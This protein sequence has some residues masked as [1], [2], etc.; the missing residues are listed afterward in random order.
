MISFLLIFY[1]LL[2]VPFLISS[3]TITNINIAE[4]F[5]LKFYEKVL[6]IVMENPR[7]SD[8]AYFPSSLRESLDSMLVADP[9]SSLM[10]MCKIALNLLKI[11]LEKV[12]NFE[13]ETEQEIYKIMESCLCEFLC[14]NSYE[15][16]F[17]GIDD[18]MVS[19]PL[20][21][22]ISEFELNRL[23]NLSFPFEPLEA[24]E[25]QDEVS[26]AVSCKK[27]KHEIE[28]ERDLDSEL[29]KSLWS[30]AIDSLAEILLKLSILTQEVEENLSQL[31]SSSADEIAISLSNNFKKYLNSKEPFSE[32]KVAQ[33][34]I[35][36][37]DYFSIKFYSKINFECNYESLDLVIKNF[38]LIFFQTSESIL[39]KA[40]ILK[41][42]EK[43]KDKKHK[44]PKK[45]Q[46]KFIQV[47]EFLSS[48][49][50]DR[51]F[52]DSVPETEAENEKKE[53]I[54]MTDEEIIE[55]PLNFLETNISK[56][57]KID[58]LRDIYNGS[59]DR[60]FGDLNPSANDTLKNIIDDA[61]YRSFLKF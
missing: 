43:V 46:E 41:E 19:D 56:S 60:D 59:I 2:S 11:E 57:I 18:L 33:D 31:L 35:E 53:E 10:E 61:I 27:R 47:E 40:N 37:I 21:A 4:N 1:F 16:I 52:V 12:G 9:N 36:E 7:L 5:E 45:D 6:N 14:P 55:N 26:V 48:N 51:N 29:S 44:N 34:F 17:D 13:A 32:E 58:R 28:M 20:L 38:K 23:E 42:S 24:K 30:M 3:P 15:N 54:I 39:I 49:S 50:N 25:D 22:P 8:L